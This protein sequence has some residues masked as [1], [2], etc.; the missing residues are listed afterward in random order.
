[1]KSN[2]KK[3]KKVYIA[4]SADILHNGHINI[5]NEGTKYGGVIIGLLTDEAIVSYKRLPLL[6]YETREKVFKN[7]KGVVDVVK[8]KTLDY[9]DNLENIKPDYVVHGD[10]WR[11]G[12]QSQIRENV[13]T[14]LKKWDGKLIEV[15]YTKGVS[16]TDLEKQLRL[17]SSTPDIRRKK[18]K[19]M[20]QLK[21]KIR[22]L[23]ASNGL[24]GLIV[25]NINVNDSEKG[26]SKEF[27]AM[28]VSSLC[29]STFKGK[30]D[31]E[32]VD[33]TSRINTI[34]EIME[35][36]SK[37]IILDGDTGGK[38]EHFV[39]N[40]KT[41]ERLGVSAIIIEDKTGLKK[42]SLFG[43]EV[44]Q[45]LENPDIF[46]EKIRAGKASQCTR[47]F[48]IFARLES[49]IAGYGVEDALDRA[50]KYIEAG[51]DGIMIHS[52]EKDGI[53]IIDF[54]KKF[55]KFSKTIPIILVPTTYNHFTDTELFEMG[56][57]II[58]HANHLL[59][60]A[61]PAML[62][63]A[64]SILKNDRSKEAD[65]QCMSIKEILTLI[66]GGK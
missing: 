49:L 12:I 30:P 19:S 8:Q 1:M 29:D 59:R 6:D 45:V 10:D 48:M 41:L 32:L 13:I 2:N 64:E 58:I 28:W 15:P 27:D 54:L 24:T 63:T 25:E 36:T 11:T 34:D 50:K 5:I 3:T 22:A 7:I 52:K 16:C 61:Y 43:T 60:S 40:V 51:A 31:I 9:T 38:T 46:A 57:N 66:P 21:K 18:L 65:K 35:V 62:K 23:E 56:A 33:L 26:L 44:K 17:I 14:Q 53:E 4:M 20:L 47:D 37:P 55:R 42:N 39:Y